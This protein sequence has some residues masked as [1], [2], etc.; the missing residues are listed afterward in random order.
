MITRK[1]DNESWQGKTNFD[2]LPVSSNQTMIK[3]WMI[4]PMNAPTAAT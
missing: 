4:T 3:L 1:I 2:T